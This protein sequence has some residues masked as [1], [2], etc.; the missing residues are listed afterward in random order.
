MLVLRPRQQEL[1]VASSEILPPTGSHQAEH[2]GSYQ[3]VN[4]PEQVKNKKGKT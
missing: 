3:S 1:V 4:Q 2:A